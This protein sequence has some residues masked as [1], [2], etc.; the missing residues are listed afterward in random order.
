MRTE[1]E[2]YKGVFI[3]IFKQ[4]ENKWALMC[5]QDTKKNQTMTVFCTGYTPKLRT[6]YEIE[7]TDNSSKYK[8][9]KRLVKYVPCL[10]EV[11]EINWEDFFSKN[12]SGV[13]KRTAQIINDEFGYKVFDLINDLDTNRE[14]LLK[15]MSEK[16]LQGFLQFYS[17]KNNRDLVKSLT[18]NGPEN[19]ENIKFFY[20]HNLIDLYEFLNNTFEIKNFVEYYKMNNPYNLYLTYNFDL[21]KIDNFAIL[22]GWNPKSIQ[23]FKAFLHKVMKD[24][25]EDNS[26][27]I[28]SKEVATNLLSYIDMDFDF[29][30]DMITQQIQNDFIKTKWIDGNL[31]FTLT[32]TYEKEE[33]ISKTLKNIQKNSSFLLKSLNLDTLNKLSEQQKEAYNSFLT[34]NVLVITGGPGTGKSFLIEKIKNTLNENGYKNEKE[35]VILA[36]TGRAATNVS[37]KINAKVKTIHSFLKIKDDDEPEQEDEDRDLI[38]VLIIDEFSM[39]NLNIF[40]KLLANLPNLKKIVLIGD[41]DQLPAIGPGNLLSDI[42]NAN[43]FETKYLY[44]FFRSDS[45]EI[46]QHF[47]NIK[48]QKAPLFSDGVVELLNFDTLDSKNKILKLYE[49]SVKEFGLKNTILLAPM[50]KGADGLVI[51]NNLIQSKINPDAKEVY[52]SKRL[53]TDVVYKINDRVM[54]TEN[55]IGDEVFNGDFGT[56]IDVKNNPFK[57]SDKKIVVSFTNEFTNITKYIEYSEREFREQIILG[58]GVTVHK[59]QGS[60]ID[61]VMFL[62]HPSHRFMLTKK[63]LYTATSRAKQKLTIITPNED[64]YRDLL[65]YPERKKENIYTNLLNLLK[66]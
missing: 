47:N 58:Y 60:E 35:Y 40:Y 26:T 3:K 64:F 16:Q 22:L 34:Q 33:F 50:Y 23:R 8:N 52:K 6:N 37:S 11:T 38:K 17:E 53:G 30:Q 59:F 15:F 55:R 51:L 39:V 29:F 24:L 20:E 14:Y 57:K 1:V 62:V 18:Q 61:N 31:Y 2:K 48:M 27:I 49:N 7:V 43:L 41:V 5:F 66:E 36:P 56:I 4:E 44:D 13:G 45:K 42:I 46:W 32:S 10:E 9:S 25:E 63:M 12:I 54:Q 21:F 65:I 28:N 19:N